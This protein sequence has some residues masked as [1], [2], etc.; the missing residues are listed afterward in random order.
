MKITKAE[1]EFM[2]LAESLG[3]EV[4]V[5]NGGM[6]R[7]RWGDRTVYPYQIMLYTPLRKIFADTELHCDGGVQGV[8]RKNGEPNWKEALGFFREIIGDGLQDCTDPDCE[9]CTEKENEEEQ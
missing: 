4:D 7:D 1:Q 6:L 9:V 2:D 5:T 3:I 8:A